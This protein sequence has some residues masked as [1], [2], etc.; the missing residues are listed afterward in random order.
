[1]TADKGELSHDSNR[2][3][4][5]SPTGW[6]QWTAAVFCSDGSATPVPNGR[7]TAPAR[8]R[9]PS[10]SLLKQVSLGEKVDLIGGVDGF[11]IRDIRISISPA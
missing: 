2:S 1:M 8:H 4:D 11:Y 6:V 3:M 7:A 9:G 10:E 5:E